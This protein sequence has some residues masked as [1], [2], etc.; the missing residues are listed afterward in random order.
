MGL[1]PRLRSHALLPLSVAALGGLAA[2]QEVVYGPDESDLLLSL[3]GSYSYRDLGDSANFDEQEVFTARLGLGYFTSRAHE[4]GF[5]LRPTVTRVE[6]AGTG[7]DVSIGPYY[8]YNF[9]TSPR[10]SFHVGPHVG[11]TYIDSSGASSDTVFSYGAHAGLRYWLNP[12]VSIEVEPRVT[13]TDSSD[14][15]DDQQAFDVLFGIAVRL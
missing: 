4:F 2:A 14:F 6:S 8:N 1:P 12:N 10:T 13:F 11:L 9:W 3:D 5:D 15:T 7:T